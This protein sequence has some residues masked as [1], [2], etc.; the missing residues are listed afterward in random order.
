MSRQV[1]DD[2]P[3]PVPDDHPLG[4]R[5]AQA[6]VDRLL[7]FAGPDTLLWERVLVAIDPE[8]ARVARQVERRARWLMDNTE[9]PVA[10]F[11]R[12]TGR[13]LHEPDTE[14]LDARSR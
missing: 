6:V 5:I 8:A 12:L 1:K 4:E 10:Q 3:P 14:K 9:N 13:T 7:G 11:E 2:V